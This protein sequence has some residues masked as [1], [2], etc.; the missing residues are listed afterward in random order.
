MSFDLRGM[1]GFGVYF[2]ICVHDDFGLNR[3]GMTGDAVLSRSPNRVQRGR[4]NAHVIDDDI[5]IVTVFYWRFDR[6]S[7]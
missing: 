3:R 1:R 6:K 5:C 4:L 2:R 7:G